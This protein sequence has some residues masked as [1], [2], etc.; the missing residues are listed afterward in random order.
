MQY[1][2]HGDNESSVKEIFFS[3]FSF[4]VNDLYSKRAIEGQDY[5]VVTNGYTYIDE[6]TSTGSVSVTIKGD[7][8]PEIDEKFVMQVTSVEVISS[9][10]STKYPPLFGSITLV[11]VVIEENDNAYGQFDLISDSPVA[12]DGGHKIGVEEKHKFAVDLVV[13]RQGKY[14]N[15]FYVS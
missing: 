6:G 1:C 9:E 7:N 3:F 4:Q 8:L 5:T 10:P 14:I 13:E 15:D 2:Y 12:V 11:T